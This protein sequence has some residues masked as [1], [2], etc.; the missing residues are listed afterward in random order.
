MTDFISRIVLWLLLS[1]AF[2]AGGVA[3]AAAQVCAAQP[4]GMLS[5]W[6][7]DGNANDQT[8]LYNGTLIG[9]AGFAPGMVG[10]AF[11]FNAPG[12]YVNAGTSDAFNFSNGMGDFTI[13]AWIRP[14]AMPPF[15]SGIVT[16]GT[17]SPYT[18]W[19]FYFYADG[20]LGFGGVGVWEFTS[21]P[22]V[23]QFNQWSH[24]AVTRSG[25]TYRLYRN[26]VEVASVG[27][28]NLETS[29][30]PL[31]FGTSYSSPAENP[32]GCDASLC[33][34]PGLIDEVQVINR[35]M[36]AAE[37]AAIY[38]AGAAGTCVTQ[39]CAPQPTG[40][41]SWWAGENNPNDFLGANNGTLVNGLTF[42]NGLV[43]RA[44]DFNGASQ[45]V[46]AADSA[47]LD[48]T[49]QFTLAA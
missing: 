30:A 9:S 26:G 8:G 11:S 42:A 28:G 34:F 14:T 25:S 49:T 39:T 37:I 12:D 27:H 38:N 5:W 16:K 31:K 43:G 35:G 24:V 45:Y 19:A 20:R 2:L 23:V 7:G 4:T 40:L 29:T 44:F 1:L 17:G 6:R 32:G 36:S 47:S 48:V 22:G 10:P 13:E 41:V 46:Q 15:A 21:V 33:G 3:P 18:G